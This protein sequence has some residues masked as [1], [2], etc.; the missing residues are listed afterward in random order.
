MKVLLIIMAIIL[1][2]CGKREVHISKSQTLIDLEE[3]VLELEKELEE[4][5]Y[6]EAIIDPCGDT[7]NVVDEVILSLSDGSYVVYFESSNKRYLA[8]LE[9]GDYRTTDGTNCNFTINDD[10]ITW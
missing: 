7:E 1:I 4:N 3:R 10:G 5:V 9:N 2:S 8:E 6:V